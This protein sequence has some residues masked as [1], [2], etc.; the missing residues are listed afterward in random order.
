MVRRN[1]RTPASFIVFGG[2]WRCCQLRLLRFFLHTLWFVFCLF[3]IQ[4]NMQITTFFAVAISTSTASYVVDR[5]KRKRYKGSRKYVNKF[6]ELLNILEKV[7]AKNHNILIWFNF[8]EPMNRKVFGVCLVSSRG[9][10][11]CN[12][13]GH[14]V[15]FIF[16][17]FL[18]HQLI[19]NAKHNKLCFSPKQYN[20]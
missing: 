1:D 9:I 6:L 12:L 14:I 2:Y 17:S 4:L 10:M 11:L 15:F 20:I 13:F 18:I 7:S 19:L 5:K 8:S 16:V 3:G